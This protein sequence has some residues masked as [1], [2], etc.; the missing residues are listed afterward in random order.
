M[1]S[2][3][4]IAYDSCYFAISRS[5]FAF[6]QAAVILT[7]I[8]AIYLKS[9]CLGTEIGQAL[10]GVGGVQCLAALYVKRD[11]Q[12]RLSIIEVVSPTQIPTIR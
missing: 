1:T 10:R 6:P 9:Y 3:A 12:K 5:P 8:F 7:A 11:C 4:A 2:S